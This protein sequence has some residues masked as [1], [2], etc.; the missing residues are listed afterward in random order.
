MD[1][2]SCDRM[3]AAV[4]EAG[5]FTAA[6]GRLGITSG[7]ASKLV[8]RLET[9]L[10]VRLL[11]RTTRA[12][13]PTEA[14]Q[15][16]FDR[17]RPLLDEFD[18]LD[19]VVRDVTQAPRGRLRLTAPLTFGELELTPILNDFALRWPE[20][21]LDVSFSDRVV[22]L[23]DEGFDMAVRI[24]RPGDS[25]MIARKLCDVRIIT[26]AAPDWL[27]TNGAPQTPQEVA[28]HGCILDTNFRD[29][30]R[31]SYRI[32]RKPIAVPVRGRLRYSN[33]QA[34]LSAAEAGLGLACVP[35][36]VA[37]AALQAGRVRQV[38]QDFEPA[39]YGIYVLYPHSRYLA[40]KVR[41]MVDFL[42]ERYR[43]QP[44]WDVDW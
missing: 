25:S 5:S 14:G 38:L 23:V 22:N 10:G 21:A 6:A 17:L 34:C 35:S 26:V 9:A 4:M 1:R 11:N 39:P 31:W 12:I 27:S 16:Y 18:S 29:P 3:F 42:A 43:G 15:A 19:A 36:F 33:A 44:P 24:G 20:I 41:V 13:S 2:L 8:A 32:N 28:A 37:G 40:A 30:E 7:Q